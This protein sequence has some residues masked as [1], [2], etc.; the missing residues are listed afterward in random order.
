[1]S[2][3]ASFTAR[4]CARLTNQLILVPLEVSGWFGECKT[5]GFSSPGGMLV[6][7]Y[8][9]R[10]GGVTLITR[11][12][13][14]PNGGQP[15]LSADTTNYVLSFLNGST[16]KLSCNDQCQETLDTVGPPNTGGGSRSLKCG[17]IALLGPSSSIASAHDRMKFPHVPGIPPCP[18]SIGSCTGA[19]LQLH[20][21]AGG[22]S[23]PFA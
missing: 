16:L 20:P 10:K 23:S 19:V 6:L 12:T 8:F 3:F 5:R 22:F 17:V 1:M 13:H 14:S 4:T 21:A 11:S 7:Q 9:Q 18:N 2:S 15:K